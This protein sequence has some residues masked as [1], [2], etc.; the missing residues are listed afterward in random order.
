MFSVWF[1]DKPKKAQQTQIENE[2]L[3]VTGVPDAELANRLAACL[4]DEFAE[5]DIKITAWVE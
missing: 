2:K 5:Y 1:A 4:V 3:F